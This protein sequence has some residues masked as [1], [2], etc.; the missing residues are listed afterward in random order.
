M[1]AAPKALHWQNTAV[2]N[3]DY[4]DKLVSKSN[5]GEGLCTFLFI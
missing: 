5:D 3:L 2:P 4:F 1:Y